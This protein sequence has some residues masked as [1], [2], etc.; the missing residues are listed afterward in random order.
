MIKRLL[1]KLL[2]PMVREVVEEQTEHLRILLKRAQEAEENQKAEQ[3]Q[4][5]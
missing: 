4:Q 1:K 5:V 3:I 2:A